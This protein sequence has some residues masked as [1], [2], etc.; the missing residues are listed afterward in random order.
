MAPA[1]S[2]HTPNRRR[3]IVGLGNPGTDYRFTRHNIGFHVADRLADSLG[4]FWKKDAFNAFWGEGVLEGTSIILAKPMAYMNR[5]GWPAWAIASRFAITAGEMLVIHDDID[6]AFG[7]LKIKE[8]GGHGGHNGL[9]SMMDA[10]GDDAF[11]RVRMGIGRP[12][13]GKEV[14]EHVLGPFSDRESEQLDEIIDRG[15]DAAV[16]VICQGT[17]AGMNRYNRKAI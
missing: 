13:P 4:I 2:P 12:D 9:R 11:T 10:F 3:L 7:T 16:T 1:D 6:L 14:T 15:K 5:S 8:K 17:M